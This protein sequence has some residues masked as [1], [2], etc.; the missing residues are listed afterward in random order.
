MTGPGGL[1]ETGADRAQLPR[2]QHVPHLI[3]PLPVTGGNGSAAPS[4]HKVEL[5]GSP[6]QFAL[7]A[8]GKSRDLCGEADPV[9]ANG[10][11]QMADIDFLE[12]LIA[13]VLR[14]V[15]RP[16]PGEDLLRREVGRFRAT[17]A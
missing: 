16:G 17:R 7:A 15:R 12:I 10:F 3:L 6:L 1:D 8:M 14:K 13:N 4:E 5:N 11:A 9:G 2:I